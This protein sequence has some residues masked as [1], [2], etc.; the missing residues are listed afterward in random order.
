MQRPI[1]RGAAAGAGLIFHIFAQD[2]ASTVGAGKASVA[3]GSWTCRYI[4]NGE[5]ISGA[6][7]P[8]DITTIG[9]YGAPTANTNIRIKAVDNTNMIGVYEVHIHL[10]WVNVTNTCQSL[11]IYLTASGVAVLPVQIPL[12]GFNRQDTVRAGLTALPNAAAEATGGLYTRGSGAGQINQQ[13]NGQIDSNLER[14]INVAPLALSAQRVQ[15]L[16]GAITN[17]VIVAATFAANALDAVWSTATRIL[18]AGTNIALAKGTGVTGFNDLSAAQV[19]AEADTALSDVGVTTTVTGRIDA[20]ISSR[21]ATAGYTAPPSAADNAD[22]V[23][24]EAIAD[25]LGAGSTG[26]ALNAAGSAG[27]PWTTPLPGAYGAG[28][29]GK[30]IGDNVN[31]TISSRASQ[32]SV[33]DVPTNAELTTALG[34]ADDAV[35]AQVALVK[36]QTDLIPAAPAAV[37]DVPTAL[38]NAD[39]LLA[40]DLGSG[41]GAGTLDERTVRSAL[42]FSRNKF[43]IAGGVLTVKK[44]D[45]T[46]TAWTSAITTTAG[47]PVSASDPA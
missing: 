39:A 35:L 7:T 33:D 41:T 32:V 17:G 27:D 30:I 4:R 2:S 15:V 9:T 24:N 18:T 13:A 23:W 37:G 6:I 19:N 25:H 26:A 5:A 44:E 29:A 8:E 31:A 45:D 46:T 34:T 12:E 3:F 14:W 28:T 42:R 38:Q 10:D 1:T 22:A 40:R 47:D 20:A 43:A 16:V 21:L 36:A 11:T